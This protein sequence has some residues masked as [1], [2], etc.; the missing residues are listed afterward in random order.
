M[1]QVQANRLV[2]LMNMM[3]TIPPKA[4][5]I[6][7]WAEFKDEKDKRGGKLV[8]LKC[9]TTACAVGWAAIEIP[10][11]KKAFKFTRNGNMYSTLTN[12]HSETFDDEFAAVAYFLGISIAEA[13]YMFNDHG[14]NKEAEADFAS[15][16]GEFKV[17]K[18]MLFAHC[19]KVLDNH[20]FV[21]AH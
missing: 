3:Q 9:D 13:D 14:Y 2:A 17:T 10:V 20:G 18:P 5:D 7:H 6:D 15:D 19:K 21:W 1:K 8:E 12:D 4:F 16:C 11:W